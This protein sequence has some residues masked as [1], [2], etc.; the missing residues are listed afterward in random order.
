M[1]VRKLEINKFIASLIKKV[2][3]NYDKPIYEYTSQA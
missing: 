3:S 1:I 2:I